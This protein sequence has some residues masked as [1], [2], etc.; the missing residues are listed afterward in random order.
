MWIGVRKGILQK[1]T[2][3]VFCAKAQRALKKLV[4][5]LFLIAFGAGA[6]R[7]FGTPVR[8]PVVPGYG[9]SIS[10]AAVF[11]TVA[12]ICKKSQDCPF[13]RQWTCAIFLKIPILLVVSS[14]L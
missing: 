12:G 7:A 8:E 1:E 2:K 10:V 6:S 14:R 5:F 9:N 13:F 11:H 3:E 4:A